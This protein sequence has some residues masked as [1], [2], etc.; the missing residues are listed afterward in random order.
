MPIAEPDAPASNPIADILGGVVKIGKQVID[1]GVKGANEL[2]SDVSQRGLGGLGEDVKAV[3]AGAISGV[4]SLPDMLANVGSAGID[5]ATGGAV[6]L[7][8]LNLAGDFANYAQGLDPSLAQHPGLTGVGS[9][10]GQLFVPG[11]GA[12]KATT[13]AGRI[14]LGALLG[15]GF[16]AA[17]DVSA[18][19]QQG[20]QQDLGASLYGGL[21]QAVIG[22]GLAALVPHGGGESEAQPVPGGIPEVTD[23]ALLAKIQNP[24]RVAG[25]TSPKSQVPPPPTHADILER[26][27]AQRPE[28]AASMEADLQREQV[29]P[30]PPEGQN[31]DLLNPQTEATQLT[32]GIDPNT[33]LAHTEQ[34]SAPEPQPVVAAQGMAVDTVPPPPEPVTHE[35]AISPQPETKGAENVP[36]G[37]TAQAVS[38]LSAPTTPA[39]PAGF[40][41]PKTYKEAITQY[42]FNP[43]TKTGF[44]AEGGHLRF[45]AD[46]E[47]VSFEAGKGFRG[48][49]SVSWY[50]A[51]NLKK[52]DS[53]KNKAFM[54]AVEAKMGAQPATESAP[55]HTP[56]PAYDE[57]TQAQYEPFHGL[58]E[59]QYNSP[60]AKKLRN[61]QYKT[62]FQQLKD[63]QGISPG[64]GSNKPYKD[65]FAYEATQNYKAAQQGEGP[66]FYKAENLAAP[67]G[68]KPEYWDRAAASDKKSLLDKLKTIGEHVKDPHLLERLMGVQT[69]SDVLKHDLPSVYLEKIK[70]EAL[71]T[72]NFANMSKE[73]LELIPYTRSATPEQILGGEGEFAKVGEAD[74]QKL[75]NYKSL[76]N[77]YINNIIKPE[78]DK[79]RVAGVTDRTIAGGGRTLRMLDEELQDA[80]S[81]WQTD[82]MLGKILKDGRSGWYKSIFLGN[83]EVAGL[84]VIEALGA[85]LSHNFPA[86]VK[87]VHSLLTDPVTRKYAQTFTT[88]GGTEARALESEHMTGLGKFQQQITQKT[89]AF[90]NVAFKA[91]DPLTQEIA[92]KK[93]GEFVGDAIRAQ[94]PEQMK[95]QLLRVAMAFDQADNLN[96]PGGAKALMQDHMDM[97]NHKAL[98]PERETLSMKAQI[99]MIDNMKRLIM[100]APPGMMEK[101]V[102]QRHG[103]MAKM[104]FPFT[105]SVIQQSRLLHSYGADFAKAVADKNILA[106]AKAAGQ[107]FTMLGVLSFFAGSA[108]I[109]KEV[110]N[111]MAQYA[112]QERDKLRG[113]LDSIHALNPTGQKVEH[114]QPKLFA[115]SMVNLGSNN[116]GVVGGQINALKGFITKSKDPEVSRRKYAHAAAT[117]AAMMQ[118]DSLAGGLVGNDKAVQLFDKLAQGLK[119]VTSTKAAYSSF[120]TKIGEG[121]R[122]KTDVF[123]EAWD[124]AVPGVRDDVA[125]FLD[126]EHDRHFQ[127]HVRSSKGDPAAFLWPN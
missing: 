76:T 65:R 111:A 117:L 75:A 30:P 1:T 46:G 38:E 113:I 110:D 107:L 11:V 112:P 57:L 95:T 2:Y 5:Y 123:Q 82:G 86:M 69:V 101:T 41:R 115:G 40:S 94:L 71:V 62:K 7:P 97:I 103:E 104:L 56:I 20:Q 53:G 42:P 124:W 13:L 51:E 3:G 34:V 79:A 120:G 114:V 61:E 8:S 99:G 78:I 36:T 10:G 77:D 58:T 39:E 67:P 74:R 55:P 49:D 25:A 12:L 28:L 125:K 102:F 60:E 19:Y 72:N 59:D 87:A 16:G 35:T 118:L 47:P 84:H 68:V 98:S 23:P 121:R 14:G 127:E 81:R 90:L 52:F 83:Q 88:R 24:H 29:P 6:H 119:G 91:M 92:G 89:D 106:G 85:G 31:L 17:G 122:F 4:L 64:A 73:G 18:R 22:A 66:V 45:Y 48:G 116:M 33:P 9:L 21:S 96:Y 100:Y 54:D 50:A 15:E 63:E 27:R 80:T 93:G 105:R 126:A 109:P 37:E 43:E 26:I 44:K 108:A 32:T 70:H